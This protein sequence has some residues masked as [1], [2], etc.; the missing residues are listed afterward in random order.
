MNDL[1]FGDSHRSNKTCIFEFDWFRWSTTAS[2][3]S[4]Y[5]SI[6]AFLIISPVF[7]RRPGAARCMEPMSSQKEGWVPAIRAWHVIIVHR[8]S[9]TLKSFL[10]S[11]MALATSAADR[12][13]CFLLGQWC[14]DRRSGD[15]LI[16]EPK[17]D[18]EVGVL[19]LERLTF[20]T[21]WYGEEG[22]SQVGFWTIKLVASSFTSMPC[23]PL[24]WPLI[25]RWLFLAKNSLHLPQFHTA[26][27]IGSWA[28]WFQIFPIKGQFQ[29]ADGTSGMSERHRYFLGSILISSWLRDLR[30]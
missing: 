21:V 22:G 4:L 7:V 16:E 1:Q 3:L 29:R 25:V 23:T 15:G 13:Y 2:L 8:M 10:S 28:P 11:E 30:L 19:G 14:C 5:Y 24:R 9:F 26:G 17:M 20:E 27:N 6:I 18:A 12:V